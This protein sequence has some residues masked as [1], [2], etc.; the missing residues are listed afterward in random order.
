MKKEGVLALAQDIPHCIQALQPISSAL[1]SLG[2]A[3]LPVC[4]RA[5]WLCRGKVRSPGTKVHLFPLHL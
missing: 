2:S 5:S 4:C 3:I 1:P